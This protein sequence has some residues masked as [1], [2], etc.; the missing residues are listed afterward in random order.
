M[1]RRF[2]GKDSEEG[3]VDILLKAPEIITVAVGPEACLRVLYFRAARKGLLPSLY[4]FPVQLLELITASHLKGLQA[5][6][7]GIVVKAETPLKG[8][9]IY[10]SCADIL[11]GTDFRKVAQDIEE[12]YHLPVKILARGPLAK[13]KDTPRERSARLLAEIEVFQHKSDISQATRILNREKAS[14][15]IQTPG[16][17]PP[18]VSDYSGVCSIVFGLNSLN[19]LISP[20]GCSQP[21]VELDEDRDFAQSHIFTTVMNDVDVTM[22]WEDKLLTDLRQIKLEKYEI[23]SLIGTPI[24]DLIGL[25]LNGLARKLE[26]RFKV[27][28]LVF[29]TAGFEAYPVGLEQGFVNLVKHLP[30]GAPDI[31]VGDIQINIL[32]YTPLVWGDER[33][34]KEFLEL[35]SGT[36]LKCNVLG[37]DSLAT[38]ARLNIVIAEEGR[39]AAE[40][41][42]EKYN[43][44]YILGLPVGVAETLRFL[45]KVENQLGMKLSSTKA[46]GELQQSLTLSQAI[47]D[48]QVL[49]IGEPFIS[50]GVQ[51]S[52]AADFGLTKIAI[53]ANIKKG[54]KSEKV[55]SHERYERVEFLTS[56]AKLLSRIAEAQ[57][58]IADP[59]YRNLIP[60]EQ[61]VIFISLPHYGLSGR[62]F[63]Q[64]EYEYIGSKGFNYLHKQLKGGIVND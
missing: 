40:W 21:I 37:R 32:G 26:G 19:I 25:N 15:V 59:L 58:I 17:L 52:L 41:L 23:I 35:F 8:I 4:L 33:H 34:L 24:S 48:K 18:L 9:I 56:E 57:I 10:I 28:V 5:L 31:P 27:K 49:I 64:T 39:K 11:M 54:T 53:I 36:A 12:R 45:L 47:L 51:K 30:V 2:V 55:F 42:Q 13:R 3:I 44:P 20:S 16:F 62:E 6:L 7:E 1:L 22:G 61:E 43:I 50:L 14:S 63:S 29:K 60:Q 46:V 38:Q